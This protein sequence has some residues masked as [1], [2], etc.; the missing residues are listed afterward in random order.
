M[1]GLASMCPAPLLPG[2]PAWLGSPV[3][4]DMGSRAGS[5]SPLCVMPPPPAVGTCDWGNPSPP[6]PYPS[7]HQAW[8]FAPQ[9]LPGYGSE[10][11]TPRE[12][13]GRADQ[14]VLRGACGLRAGRG[15][16][17]VSVNLCKSLCSQPQWPHP[18]WESY[19]VACTALLE[20]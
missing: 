18:N 7:C 17:S 14:E 6:S 13:E 19:F 12:E 8:A 15:F 10:T 9:E 16:A 2:N 1:R 3:E 11:P 5:P 20:D 4:K